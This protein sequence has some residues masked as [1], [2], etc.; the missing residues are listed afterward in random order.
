MFFRF[1]SVS[2]ESL[3]PLRAVELSKQE[4]RCSVVVHFSRA[5]AGPL[6]LVARSMLL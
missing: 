6:F 3:A 5:F 1:P 4:A 2:F